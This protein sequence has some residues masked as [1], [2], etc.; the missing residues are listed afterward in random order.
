VEIVVNGRTAMMEI[1]NF[2]IHMEN[3]MTTKENNGKRS[4]KDK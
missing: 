3:G 4:H 2:I 1:I